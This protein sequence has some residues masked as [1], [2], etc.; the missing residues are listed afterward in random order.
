MT[1]TE[2]LEALE[3]RIQNWI[4]EQTRIAKEIQYELNAIERERDID[5]GKI[6]KLAYEADVYETLIQESQCQIQAL[7]EEA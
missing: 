6:R 4:E 2:N 5:F 3:T 1:N 7:E